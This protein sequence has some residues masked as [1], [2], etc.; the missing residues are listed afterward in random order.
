[1]CPR[2]YWWGQIR[3]A[4]A[5]IPVEK[6]G[7][8]MVRHASFLGLREDEPAEDVVAE[9]TPA[10]TESAPGAPPFGVA[11]THPDRVIFDGDGRTKADLAAY[12]A[13]MAEPML[14]WLAARPVSLVRC[15]QGRARHC[16]FQKHH[17][18]AF[19]GKVDHVAIREKDGGTA[20]YLVVND[21]EAL[22]TCVQMNSIEFHGW[23]A[24]AADVEHPDRLVFDLD[25]E[26]GL[27]FA[28][29]RHGALQL[30]DLLGEMGLATFPMATGG[31]GVH[32]IA[33]LDGSADWGAVK[34][35]AA[36]FAR[37]VAEAHPTRFTANMRKAER[38]GRI[39]LDWL[40]NERG[41]TAVMPYSAR[42][43]EV[44]SVAAPI[45]WDELADLKDAR[46][47][48][49]DDAAELVARARSRELRDWCRKPQRL[50]GI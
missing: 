25:P 1:M 16:F 3:L 32:V 47:F 20:D 40:R 19:G 12:Y 14:R 46:P 22:L 11:I 43:R 39:F 50:P 44:S 27:D 31:K 29:V 33:S 45:G 42:A 9:K 36:R 26:E 30:R 7:D 4:P 35:F 5:S 8:G 17:S 38:K 13:A 15:P 41:A 2:A 6:T 23:G 21:G 18:G 34:D 48:H 28:E 49:I 10:T 24:P 37:A